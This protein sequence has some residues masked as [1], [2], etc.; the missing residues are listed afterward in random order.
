MV[1]EAGL[2]IRPKQTAIGG[3]WHFEIAVNQAIVKLDFEGVQM[4]AEPNC[5]ER[6]GLHRGARDMRNDRFDR[7]I[8]RLHLSGK[9]ERDNE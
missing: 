1:V 3:G 5:G 9:N 7:A 8:G 6:A 2:G 4:L